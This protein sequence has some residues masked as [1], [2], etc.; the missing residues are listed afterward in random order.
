MLRN[1]I[2]INSNT[3]E[4]LPPHLMAMLPHRAIS[5]LERFGGRIEEI[6]LRSMRCISLTSEGRNIMLDTVLT[7]AEMEQTLKSMCSDSLYAYSETINRGFL[8][9]DGGIRVGVCGRAACENDKIIGV[10]SISALN[11]RIPHRIQRPD[12]GVLSVCELLRSGG[13]LVYSP[14]GV[15]KTTFLRSAVAA[16]AGGDKPWRVVVIDTRG[17]LSFSLDS[18]R[19]CLDILSGYPRAAGVDIA[20]R[21]MNAQLIVCDE[22]GDLSEALAIV[23]AHNCGV[24]LLA[25]AHAGSVGELLRRK[26][27]SLLHRSGIF[28]SYVGL[29]RTGDGFSYRTTSAREVNGVF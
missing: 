20:A 27:I 6:R 4:K 7:Q 11:I 25:T 9:L 12:K 19:M 2:I 22:I 24:P 16:L 5:E 13:V 8:T 18:S 3:R 14:P 23:S 10:Y 1:N 17:E 29:N 21:T 26:S 28:G 15:G